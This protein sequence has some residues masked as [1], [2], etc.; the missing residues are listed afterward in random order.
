V[1]ITLCT[2]TC[3]RQV[4]ILIYVVILGIMADVPLL[5]ISENSSS[6]RRITPSWSISQL[7]SK[8]EPITGI[9]PPCQRLKLKT[10][11]NEAVAIESGDEDCTQLSHFP[12]APYAELQVRDQK[13]LAV[14]WPYRTA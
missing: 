3:L 9:P 2:D 5:V 4:H 11:D 6:E 7:K 13:R 10:S 8:L 12:L 1:G 14:F